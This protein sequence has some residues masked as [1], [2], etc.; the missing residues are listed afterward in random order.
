M[1]ICIATSAFPINSNEPYHRYIDDLIKILVK[2]NHV[3]TILTQEKKGQK[4]NFH[5]G[6]EVIWFPWKMTGKIGLAEISLKK[7]KDIISTFSLIFNGVKY[8][9]K[10]TKEKNI[11]LF[12]CLWIVPSGLYIFLKNIISPQTPYFLWA[13]GSDVNNYKD[14]LIT[15]FFL[16]LIIRNSK[17]VFADGF[18]L[19]ENIR[20]ISGRECE[21]LPTFHKINIPENAGKKNNNPGKEISF[22]YV[23]RLTHIKGVDIL[24]DS[25]RILKKENSHLNFKCN[26]I[27]DG[28]LMP[29][30]VNEL[31]KNEL[32]SSVFLLGKIMDE[33]KF[34]EYFSSADCI[35]I[36]SRSESI[37][38]VLSEAIQFG[39]PVIVSNAGDMEFLVK[40]YNL[41]LVAEKE[42]SASLA[43]A[44][45]KFIA[46]PLQINQDDRNTLLNNLLFEKS[47]R[48]L[49][50]TIS[51]VK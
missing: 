35:I 29:L 45:K 32:E 4:E 46:K 43:G 3:V 5:P 36:P 51:N 28:E 6:I 14:N 25:F 9:R 22:L 41:G 20:K 47:S 8:C 44:I 30:L 23:G 19:C 40:K 48:K 1:N 27:G 50:N 13:L 34:S 7:L 26:I 31:R 17:A 2:N 12:I 15:R 38:I 10:I 42:D 37:P 16:R 33:K 21:F 24:A 18:E 11:D 39:K 49:L